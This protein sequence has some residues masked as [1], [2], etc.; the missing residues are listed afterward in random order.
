MNASA[1]ADDNYRTEPDGVKGGDTSWIHL[2]PGQP[3]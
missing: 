1:V 2:S 3:R